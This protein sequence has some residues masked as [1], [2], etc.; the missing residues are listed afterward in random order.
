MMVAG[1]SLLEASQ[2]ELSYT[3]RKSIYIKKND[4]SNLPVTAEWCSSHR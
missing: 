2:E 4:I 1:S 3:C